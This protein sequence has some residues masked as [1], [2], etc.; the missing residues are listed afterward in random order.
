M[1]ALVRMRL[2]PRVAPVLLR[3]LTPC[4]GLLLDAWGAPPARAQAN[5]GA[6]STARRAPSAL[7]PAGAGAAAGSS[8]STAD[9]DAATWV[10]T[11]ADDLA[12]QLAEVGPSHRASLA[13]VMAKRLYN[14]ARRVAVS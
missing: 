6:A 10:R 4:L 9:E 12:A 2:D 13:A 8:S 5:G 11:W 7:P 3:E 14:R 1:L